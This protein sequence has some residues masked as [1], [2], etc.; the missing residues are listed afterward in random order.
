MKTKLFFL[1]AFLIGF[2]AQSQK[3]EVKQKVLNR[4]SIPEFIEFKAKKQFYTKNQ[5]KEVFRRYLNLTPPQDQ[6]RKTRTSTD[7][8]GQTHIKY[9]QYYKGIKVEYGQYKAHLTDDKIRMI[10][11]NYIPVKNISVKPGISG[12]AALHKALEQ[13]GA[14]KYAWES[15]GMEQMIKEEKRD[16]KASY[17]PD[18]T[19]VIWSAYKGEK[20]RLAYRFNIFALN[21]PTREYVF[22]DAKNGTIL[23]IEPIMVHA[24]GEADTRYSGTRNFTTQSYNNRYRLKDI[25]RGNDIITMDMNEDTDFSNAEHFYD[26]NNDWTAEEYNNANKDNAALDVHW[27]AQKTFDYFKNEHDHDSYD[28]NGS[29]TV[30]CYVHFGKEWPNAAWSGS[31]LLFGDGDDVNIEAL[32]SLDITAHEFGHAVCDY[33]CDLRYENESGALNE[34]FSDIWGA[35]VEEYAAPEKDLWKAGEEV[36]LNQTANRALDEPNLITYQAPDG[37]TYPYP[38]TYQGEGW[39][40]G[41]WDNGGVHINSTVLSHWFYLLSEGGSGTNDNGDCY[42]LDGI[43]IEKASK[44]VY[45]LETVYLDQESD[46]SE[47]RNF[48]IQA[49]KD[50]YGNNSVEAIETT[51]AWYAVGIGNYN[52]LISGTSPLCTSFKTYTLQNIP[53]GCSA[54]WSATP[55]HLFTNTSGTGS[56]FT[57]AWDGSGSG[58]GTIT[59][60]LSGDCGSVDITKTIWVGSPAIPDGIK[61]LPPGGVCRGRDYSYDVS[62]MDDNMYYVD[63]YN[64]DLHYPGDIMKD[65]GQS[66][67]F[68]YPSS[69]LTGRYSVAVQSKNDCGTSPYHIAYFDVIDCEGSPAPLSLYPVPADVQM[70]VT[71]EEPTGDKT[72]IQTSQQSEHKYYLYNDRYMLVK[73]GNVRSNVFQVSTNHLPEGFYFLRVE[74]SKDTYTRKLEIRH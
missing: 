69:T 2:S 39:Y 10:S 72:N 66:I 35:C 27:G 3:P 32:T 25:T 41:S 28:G 57:T 23:D 19:I 22:V 8:L 70:R 9:Q 38:D 18:G 31:K 53:S 11:G 46:Y 29:E 45:R 63:T 17:Y 5:T 15:R 37:K 73:Q 64:W 47:A 55:T 6:M 26:S 61:Y 36:N 56:S 13:V 33:T 48:A 54:N 43:G 52:K 34:G 30:R 59:A 68:S 1:I 7:K 74:T 50:L 40:S 67:R 60:T 21:P 44:I 49:A 62:V 14:N 58:M 12:K 20:V 4:D 24:T 16:D 65:N 71:I 42:Y 51:N